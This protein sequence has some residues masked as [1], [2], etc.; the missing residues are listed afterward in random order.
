MRRPGAGRPRPAHSWRGRLT[1]RRPASAG[2]ARGGGGRPA[3]TGRALVLAVTLA[4]IAV[5]LAVPV[6]VYLG[7]RSAVA[8]LAGQIRVQEAR[9]AAL[10]AQQQAWSSPA[11]VMA[12]ARSRLHYV[13]PG[14]TDYIVL[15]A[16]SGGTGS[17]ASGAAGGSAGSAVNSAQLGAGPASEPAWYTQLWDSVRASA[18]TPAG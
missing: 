15:G 5:A 17:G 11:Y 18:Q 8:A 12:Q 10:R 2:P 4:S 9:I 6:K 7:Q 1:R 16:P 14:E 13:L 3:L